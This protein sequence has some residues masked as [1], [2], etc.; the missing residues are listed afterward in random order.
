MK[1]QYIL[2]DWLNALFYLLEQF[3]YVLEVLLFLY[4][5]LGTAL[6]KLR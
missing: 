6:I 2:N 3:H 1:G 4:I 5:L